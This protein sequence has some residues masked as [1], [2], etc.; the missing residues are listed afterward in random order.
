MAPTPSADDTQRRVEQLEAR[1]RE[2]TEQATETRTQRTLLA[3][4][5]ALL[6]GSAL[7]GASVVV[8]DRSRLDVIESRMRDVE[9]TSRETQSDQRALATTLAELRTDLRVIGSQITDVRDRAARIEAQ[10]SQPA[11]F[12]PTRR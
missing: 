9:R 5:A 1:E 11:G 7:T 10:L 3:G 4:L 8:Q 12:T 6:F 2:L